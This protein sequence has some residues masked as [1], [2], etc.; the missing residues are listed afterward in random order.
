[1]STKILFRRDTAANWATVNPVLLAGEIGIE[2]DTYKFKIGNGSRWNQQPFYAFKVG[3]PLGVAQLGATGK[4]PVDQMPDYASVNLEVTQKVNDKFASQTTS[5]LPEG[6]NLYFTEARA[7]AVSANAITAALSSEA[8]TRNAAILAAKNEAISTADTHTAISI[9]ASKAETLAEAYSE[10]TDI[11]SSLVSQEATAR[12]AEISEAISE[13]TLNRTSAINTAISNEI[14]NRNIAINSTTT[15]Q[16]AEG[17][18][19]YF[20]ASRAKSAVASDIAAAV[21]TVSFSGKTT[22]DLAEGSRLYFT[23]QRAIAA[24]QPAL[25]SQ[26]TFVNNSMETLYQMVSDNFVS[27]STLTNQL[28]SYILDADRNQPGGFAGLN[29]SSQILESVI[30]ST[31]ARTSDITNAVAGL[32]N[33]APSSLDTLGELATALQNDQSAASALTT[34]VGTKLSSAIAATT[35]APIASPT[36]TGVVSGV[37]KTHV[38]LSNVDNTSDLDKPISSATQNALDLKAPLNNPQFTGAIDFTGVN[39]TGLTAVSGLPDQSSNSGKYLMTDGINPSWETLDVS[40]YA[41]L[42]N[43]SFTGTVSFID[44]AVNFADGSITNANLA[45]L[46]QN[47]KL[48]N[49]SITLNGNL[50][51][52]GATATLGGYYNPAS[53]NARNKIIYG[54]SVDAPSGDYVAGDIYIQY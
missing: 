6:T 54:T 34:L 45:G 22:S 30:P 29:S 50:I 28:D 33:S 37:T 43:P 20:T 35:Y 32:V 12:S 16:I 7:A 44:A 51:N 31:I 36:F 10:A 53:E 14:I 13:E 24:L 48:E 40:A 1:M 47:N 25:T 4:I 38:G 46:I 39:V 3:S 49:S 9:A 52:L 15:T 23:N 2:T 5:N 19:L 26:T 27:N 17:D 18:N 8:T 21:A 41:P 11:A 42:S